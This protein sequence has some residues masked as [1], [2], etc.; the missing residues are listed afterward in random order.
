MQDYSHYLAL[1]KMGPLYKSEHK[2]IK[3]MPEQ[4]QK[5]RNQSDHPRL[6]KHPKT[7]K[8]QISDV[9]CFLADFGRFLSLE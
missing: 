4:M 3:N 9:A 2:S 8:N 7:I 1:L 5:T 6:R